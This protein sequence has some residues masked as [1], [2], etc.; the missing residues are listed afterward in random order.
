MLSKFSFVR[1]PLLYK[2][3]KTNKQKQAMAA[4]VFCEKADIRAR[5]HQQPPA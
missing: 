2:W 3:G 5:Q 1:F 4:N